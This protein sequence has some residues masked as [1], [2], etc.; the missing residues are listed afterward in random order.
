MMASWV[1]VYLGTNHE[2][3]GKVSEEIRRIASRYSKPGVPALE[4]LSNIPVQA[5]QSEF[6]L[7]NACLRETIRMQLCG[8]LF[9]KSTA[10]EAIPL[11]SGEVIPGGSVVVSDL[12]QS[13]FVLYS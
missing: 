11:R 7:L 8:C 2:W 6:V 5:W 3:Q 9:R 4:Q 1:T 13:S 12:A 10:A